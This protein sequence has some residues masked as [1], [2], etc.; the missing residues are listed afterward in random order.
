M[1]NARVSSLGVCVLSLSVVACGGGG[2]GPSAASPTQ[3]ESAGGSDATDFT[4]NDVQGRSVSLS[5]YLGKTAIVVNFWA[6]WCKP[7]AIEM[8]HLQKMYDARKD[9]GFVVL[10]VSIDRSDT[11]AEVAPFVKKKGYTFPVLLDTESRAMS[12]YN[13]RGAAP[14]TVIIDKRGKIVKQRE[15][16]NPGD[17]AQLEADVDAAMK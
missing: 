5:Q 4:L 2:S 8:P 15:G 6:T 1:R 9:K 10:A 3:T 7:C 12:I 13:P 14:Y 17:E 11:E 16:F